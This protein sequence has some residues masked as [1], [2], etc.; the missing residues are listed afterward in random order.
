A[1]LCGR[2]WATADLGAAG[3]RTP[4]APAAARQRQGRPRR[5][6]YA[7]AARLVS[8]RAAGRYARGVQPTETLVYATPMRTRFRGIVER[9]GMLVR[10][11]AGWAEFSPFADY[12]ARTSAP[13]LAA[14]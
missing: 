10:G 11:P 13:W 1:R 2:P 12:D 6:A 5:P 4:G 9:Q 14:A 7:R 8:G 3:R